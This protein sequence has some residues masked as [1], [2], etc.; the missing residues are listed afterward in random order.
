MTRRGAISL[1]VAAFV[2]VAGAACWIVWVSGLTAAARLRRQLG[3]D[4]YTTDTIRAGLL[5]RIP[6]GSTADA[7]VA[8]L[9]DHGIREDAS[10]N[11]GRKDDELTCVVWPD[12][13]APD[14]IGGEHYYI[15]FDLDASHRLRDIRVKRGILRALNSGGFRGESRP[16]PSRAPGRYARSALH[17]GTHDARGVVAAV[18]L[19]QDQRALDQGR[20]AVGERSR[21]SARRRRRRA[22]G[23]GSGRGPRAC[24]R[25]RPGGPGRADSGTRPP[26]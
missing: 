15:H 3:I 1:L 7:I 2:V 16:A 12:D 17:R 18:G 25:R 13:R 6:A 22:R 23:R 21:P 10:T 19:P 4:T 8:F 20:V 14:F 24:A 9:A 26:C 11:L 5:D